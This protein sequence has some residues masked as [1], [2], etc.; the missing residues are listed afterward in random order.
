[1]ANFAAFSPLGVLVPLLVRNVLNQGA[2][3]FGLVLAAGGL[4]GAIASLLVARFGAPRRRITS[5]WLAWGLAGA[6][7]LGLALAPGVWIAGIF[8]M[9]VYGLLE[10]GN[11]LWNP[12]MQELV[13]PEL[14]GRASSVDW[15]VSIS[16]SPLG[17]LVAGLVAGSIGTRTTMLL[18]GGVATLAAAVLFVPGVRDPERLGS[19]RQ[20]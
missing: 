10:Y 7:L 15:L 19:S 18:S 8:L 2:L 20:R 13:P 5:M 12:L 1:V 9:V 11:V 3:A 4:G 14:I 16:L 17:V 6:S